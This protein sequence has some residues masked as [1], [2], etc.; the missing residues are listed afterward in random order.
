MIKT[1]NDIDQN[2]EYVYISDSQNIEE[3][4]K[5]L[6]PQNLVKEVLEE[7]GLLFVKIED[8][9]YKEIYFSSYSIPYLSYRLYDF[10]KYF[11]LKN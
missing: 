11:D 10:F 2:P 5:S 9:D 4:I 3:I 6:I 7:I 1:I 8:S